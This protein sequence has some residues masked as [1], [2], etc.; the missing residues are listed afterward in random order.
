MKQCL[1]NMHQ[2]YEPVAGLSDI[3]NAA[4][5]AQCDPFGA[6]VNVGNHDIQTP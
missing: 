3:N 6:E 5:S 2:Q 4:L 1:P